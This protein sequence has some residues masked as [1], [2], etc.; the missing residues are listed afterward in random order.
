MTP[1]QTSEN[2]NLALKHRLYVSGWMLSSSLIHA[3]E[4]PR[5]YY[6]NLKYN[7]EGLPIGVIC[8]HIRGINNEIGS[9]QV[10]VRKSERRKGY[11]TELINIMYDEWS[12]I[13]L[14][15][16]DGI[17]GSRLFWENTIIK[18]EN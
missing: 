2:A 4:Y 1:E 18:S 5:H 7:D 15:H 10:F 3:R 12:G 13:S 8:V 17:K 11:G 16:D 9:I 6:I 14:R